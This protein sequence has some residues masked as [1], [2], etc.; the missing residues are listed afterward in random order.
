ME[1]GAR[2]LADL[3]RLSQMEQAEKI[4]S[5]LRTL[6]E[7]IDRDL[8]RVEEVLTRLQFSTKLQRE[9]MLDFLEL[10]HYDQGKFSLAND[11]F[12]LPQLIEQVFELMAEHAKEKN[13]RFNIEVSDIKLFKS[14]Y[15]DRKRYL[16]LLL[17][18]VGQAVKWSMRNS[19]ITVLLKVKQIK[20]WEACDDHPKSTRQLGE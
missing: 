13:A 15:G 12:N 3:D 7:Y 2:M 6:G 18:F 11:Y 14:V 16:Q 8:V 10:A 19:V 5:K 9:L 1:V 17:N 20:F 4:I